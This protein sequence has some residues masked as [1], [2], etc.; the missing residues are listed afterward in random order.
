[1]K[2]PLI[3]VNFAAVFKGK[4]YGDKL[5]SKRLVFH[6]DQAATDL[7]SLLSIGAAPEGGL[8]KW[9]SGVAI[10]NELIRRGRTVSSRLQKQFANASI[11]SE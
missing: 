7:I 10:H 5:N 6:S 3:V 2:P 4:G 9:V 11:D 8:S 1:M